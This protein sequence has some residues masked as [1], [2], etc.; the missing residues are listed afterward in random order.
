MQL[1]PSKLVIG[2]D[3]DELP[4]LQFGPAHPSRGERY[5]KPRFGAGDDA[6]GRG[7]V[8][9]PVYS[10]ER[11]SP[12]PREIPAT[13]AGET[14]AEN[15]V[16]PSEVGGR[17]RRSPARKVGRRRNGEARRL[18]LQPRAESRI[19]QWAEP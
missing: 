4:C 11:G 5:S 12:R 6:V 19:G 18:A 15:A 3:C 16:V 17:L 9:W 7:D 13:S 14:G 2:E 1:E 8:Y 10:H